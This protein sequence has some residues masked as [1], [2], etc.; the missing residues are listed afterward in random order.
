MKYNPK[1][2]CVLFY[3]LNIFPAIFVIALLL[4]YFHTGYILG[5]LPIESLDDPKNLSIYSFYAPVI[6]LSFGISFCLFFVSLICLIFYLLLNKKNRIWKPI[7]IL[8]SIQIMAIVLFYSKI[9][10]WFGD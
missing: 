8:I 6:W 9:T 2:W 10:T 5:H 1:T 7:I 4:F 3:S